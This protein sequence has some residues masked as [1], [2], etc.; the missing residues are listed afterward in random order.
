MPGILLP[1]PKWHV[2]SISFLLIFFSNLFYLSHQNI[3]PRNGEDFFFFFFFGPILHSYI[4]S[5]KNNGQCRMDT[6]SILVGNRHV[7]LNQWADSQQRGWQSVEARWACFPSL[8]HSRKHICQLLRDSALGSGRILLP[9]K[10]TWLFGRVR[11][12]M[13][14]GHN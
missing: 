11:Q 14:N 1:H 10:T 2:R 8:P 3:N 6:Q 13:T 7:W 5:T 9:V 4:P 12:E